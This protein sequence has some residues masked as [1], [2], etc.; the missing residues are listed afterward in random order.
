MGECDGLNCSPDL[1]ITTKPHGVAVGLPVSMI[2]HGKV[3]IPCALF[4]DSLS[5]RLR[6]IAVVWGASA[7]ASLP[8]WPP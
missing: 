7:P 3:S 1:G 8:W 2:A 6:G 4:S 5:N